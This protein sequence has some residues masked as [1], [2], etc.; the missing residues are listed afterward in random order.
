M[1]SSSSSCAR[2]GARRLVRGMMGGVD[3][4]E[5]MPEPAAVDDNDDGDEVGATGIP[6]NLRMAASR[7]AVRLISFDPSPGLLEAAAVHSSGGIGP[8]PATCSVSNPSLDA[9]TLAHMSRDDV[10]LKLERSAS[11]TGGSDLAAL[12]EE[13]EPRLNE[14]DEE[15]GEAV[16]GGLDEAA[17]DEEGW[18]NGGYWVLLNA[19][20]MAWTECVEF[21]KTSYCYVVTCVE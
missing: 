7:R 19:D 16:L 1:T 2:G 10:T 6:D 4:L 12:V 17:A 15:D 13:T 21:L 20:M 3:V 18:T 14:K 5:R 8:R 9:S 11:V